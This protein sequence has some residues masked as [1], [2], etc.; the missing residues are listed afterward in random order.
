LW[1]TVITKG[2]NVYRRADGSPDFIKVNDST[3]K[4]FNAQAWVN[5]YYK[6]STKIGTKPDNITLLALGMQDPKEFKVTPNRAKSDDSEDP[7]S[8]SLT[9]R[10]FLHSIACFTSKEAGIVAGMYFIDKK[11]KRGLIYE[12]LLVI[13][14]GSTSSPLATVQVNTGINSTSLKPK[15][16]NDITNK[17]KTT[18]KWKKLDTTFNFVPFYEVFRSEN[19]D[20]NFISLTTDPL[21]S[22]FQSSKEDSTNVMYRDTT[23][24]KDQVYYYKV[25]GIDI[26]WEKT[27]YSDPYRIRETTKMEIPP[28]ITKAECVEKKFNRITWDYDLKEKELV[29]GFRVYR[30]QFADTLYT[31][32]TGDLSVSSTTIEDKNPLLDGYYKVMSKGK[33]NDTLWSFPTYVHIADSIPPQPPT[34]ISGSCDSNGIVRI[35]WLH[36]K[37]KDLLAY[38]L[39][40]AN[41]KE[42]EFSG[43]K[44]AE[45]LDSI[46][47]D[48]L[49][50]HTL[51]EEVYYKMQLLDNNYNTSLYSNIIKVKRVDTIPPVP[52]VFYTIKS[53]TS[54]I[55]LVWSNSPNEDLLKTVLFRKLRDETSWHEYKTFPSDT[56]KFTA[57]VD[58]S[59]YK[60]MWYQYK[61]QCFDDDKNK[62]IFSKVIEVR[63]LDDGFRPE[64]KNF[65]LKGEVKKKMIKLSWQYNE[66]GVKFIQIYRADNGRPLSILKSLEPGSVGYY[67][68]EVGAGNEY[69]YQIRALFKDGGA[70]PFTKEVVVKF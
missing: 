8:D 45:K 53:D 61:L 7:F 11:V 22:I 57:F 65:T 21:F 34:L 17:R 40:K 10:H 12:Y 50:L 26:F 47:V 66:P 3:I 28:K 58:K 39:L 48:T 9:T 44:Y 4:A 38:R 55:G 64:I 68:R 49:N 35:K 6:D 31:P 46:I 19:K 33:A 70:S 67:D 30:S 15:I 5:Y 63:A 18:F 29:V 13:E 23:L 2:V 32:L 59:Y 14:G 62:S 69:R 52:P 16:L 36:H 56:S 24:M 25:I 51:T 1:E 60:G 41:H 42:D 27:E 20:N 43:M 37:E 54:G